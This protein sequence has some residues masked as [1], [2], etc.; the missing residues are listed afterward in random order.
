MAGCSVELRRRWIGLGR[1]RGD[2]LPGVKLGFVTVSWWRGQLRNVM[3]EKIA[4]A[5]QF[6]R[7]ERR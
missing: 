7:R 2:L 4:D 5:V 3:A 6:V 1:I